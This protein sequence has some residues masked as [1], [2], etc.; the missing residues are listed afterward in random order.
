MMIAA[1]S[2]AALRDERGQVM[3][4]L[5]VMIFL[6]LAGGVALLAVGHTSS[7]RARAQ[8]AADAAALAGA[9][10]IKR[11][12]Q[13]SD[14]PG[15]LA[16]DDAA[17][18]NA[19]AR[20]AALNG[21]TLTSYQRLGDDVL[22]GAVTDARQRTSDGH[23]VA[24]EAQARATV[25]ATVGGLSGG[26]V[27]SIPAA[28]PGPG[29]RVGAIIR[30]AARINALNLSYT[31]GGSHGLNLASPNGPF[32]CSS[33]VSRVLQA[34]GYRIPVMLSG[35]FANFGAPGPGQI[36][37][38]VIPGSGA[39]GHVYLVIND[40]HGNTRAWGTGGNAQGGPGWISGYTYQYPGRQVILRH[41]PDLG[42]NFDPS[43]L[44]LGSQYVPSAP[45][46]IT[47]DVHL[48]PL[49]GPPTSVAAGSLAAGAP[50]PTSASAN[51]IADTILR[52]AQGMH[53]DAKV[54]LAAYETAI[55][56]SNL[57]NLPPGAGDR[58]SVGVFQQRPSTGWGSPTNPTDLNDVSYSASLFLR[59]AV[60]ADAANPS[61]TPGQLAQTVQRSA[62]PDRYDQ[63]QGQ[64]QQVLSAARSRAGHG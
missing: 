41:L 16:V 25:A 14:G 32:D 24:G 61:L 5:L 7:L 44:N 35:D 13:F 22:V 12:L 9:D 55:V 56:E 33:A 57:R 21:A 52:V 30:E 19:A 23:S 31:Y 49:S 3:P 45:S 8:T 15:P 39:N 10:E 50:T 47:L 2:W 20:Y 36:T 40:G 58:D 62:Y 59:A 51:Q 6:L 27:Q 64:A 42:G 43:K 17:V 18:R 4:L 38:V 48:V 63:A 53:V 37:I 26:G 1:R 11:E 46:S 54:L 34:A 28:P 60:Q 29:G